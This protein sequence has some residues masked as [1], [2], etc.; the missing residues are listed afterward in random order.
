MP[1]QEERPACF[2]VRQALPKASPARA[3]WTTPDIDLAPT[4]LQLLGV[5]VPELIDGRVLSEALDA[6]TGARVATTASGEVG[7]ATAAQA[8]EANRADARYSEEENEKIEDRLRDLG[9]ID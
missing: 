8:E 7:A 4:V 3:Y 2:Q 5:P 6:R 1:A 9:Y